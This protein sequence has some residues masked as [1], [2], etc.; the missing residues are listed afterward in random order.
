MRIFFT[1]F[2][3]HPY[4]LFLLAVV[5]SLEKKKKNHSTIARALGIINRTL[6]FSLNFF[7]HIHITSVSYSFS[8]SSLFQTTKSYIT[9]TT[10]PSG[11]YYNRGTFAGPRNE[12]ITHLLFPSSL[13][14]LIQHTHFFFLI[15]I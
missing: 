12:S 13:H 2:Y 11:A 8:N 9:E 10:F 3:T 14:S 4:S 6:L 5:R 1:P 7:S 15:L